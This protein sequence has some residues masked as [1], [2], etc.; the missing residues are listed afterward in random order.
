[1]LSICTIWGLST[2]VISGVV[3][4]CQLSR[5]TL[6][7]FS[8]S[9]DVLCALR[10]QLLK[11]FFKRVVCPPPHFLSGPSQKPPKDSPCL[12]PRFLSVC[13]TTSRR[14]GGAALHSGKQ[15]ESPVLMRLTASWEIQTRTLIILRYN[16]VSPALPSQLSAGESSFLDPSMTHPAQRKMQSLERGCVVL[17]LGPSVAEERKLS[18]QRPKKHSSLEAA[19]VESRRRPVER[20]HSWPLPGLDDI[21]P[22]TVLASWAG[23][24]RRAWFPIHSSLE[25]RRGVLLHRLWTT[26]DIGPPASR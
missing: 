9:L 10:F 26:A 19:K 5:T 2:A 11:G 16:R 23:H 4:S 18:T 12:Q 20:A 7:Q 14:T 21:H 6:G 24:G 22:Y 15:S 3:E 17:G 25:E 1:M 13:H 8:Q